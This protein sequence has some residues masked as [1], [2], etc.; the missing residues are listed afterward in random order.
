MPWEMHSGTRTDTANPI[1]QTKASQTSFFV[2]VS[3]VSKESMKWE[4]QRKLFSLP[5]SCCHQHWADHTEEGWSATA[6]HIPIPQALS[7]HN[8]WHKVSI[9]P[10]HLL[11]LS[12]F[13]SFQAPALSFHHHH[14]YWSSNYSPKWNKIKI[15][16]PCFR[17]EPFPD[18]FP[19]SVEG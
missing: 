19:L 12:Q 14:H 18:L 3:D 16:L 5:E 7:Y 15:V 2:C 13:R 8:P 4:D 9:A 6:Q 10:L 1:I 11:E 17:K